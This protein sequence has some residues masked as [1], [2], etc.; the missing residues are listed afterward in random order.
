MI[1]SLQL[2]KGVV[3]GGMKPWIIILIALLAA[4]IIAAVVRCIFEL[5][6][7]T[8]SRYSLHS[9]KVAP[10][11]E[12]KLVFL[13]DLHSREYGEGNEELK[14][15][16]E[17][18]TPDIIL[19]GGDMIVSATGKDDS[20]TRRF[21]SRISDIAPIYY[22]PGNHEKVIESLKS[23]RTRN[24]N[25]VGFLNSLGIKYLKNETVDINGSVSVT[26]LDVAYEYYGKIRPR[27]MTVQALTGYLGKTDRS[28]YNIIL[29]HNP[30]FF[31]Q[32]ARTDSDLVLSG[33]YHGGSIRL[34]LV[35]GIISPQFR[36][37][38]DH[39]K[40]KFEKNG[41]TMIVTGG[42]G[43]HTVNLRLFNRPEIVV[44]SIEGSEVGN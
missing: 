23:C 44:I 41:T 9:P 40:G 21:L 3:S 18:E 28:R 22:A 43:S 2:C 13:S 30:G 32:Y 6:S 12:L 27:K 5:R 11:D 14:K 31:E 35:G 34:P 15:L 24:R 8:V 25:Y 10:G 38:P 29:A 16:I 39:S 26:G 37:F 7:L 4:L 42:C 17:N 19:I 33:H 20:K 36:L 1:K